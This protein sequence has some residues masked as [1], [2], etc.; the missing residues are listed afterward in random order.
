ML[1][2]ILAAVVVAGLVLY[3]R[4][5]NLAKTDLNAKLNPMWDRMAKRNRCTRAAGVGRGHG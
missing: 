5:H 3:Q 2:L 1:G 4:R